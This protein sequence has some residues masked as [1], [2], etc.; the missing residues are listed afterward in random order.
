M[1][2]RFTTEAARR[3][4][5][6]LAEALAV[7]YVEM[8]SRGGDA[9]SAAV[10]DRLRKLVQELYLLSGDDLVRFDEVR[11]ECRVMNDHDVAD[12]IPAAGWYMAL[13]DP[14]FAEGRDP[15]TDEELIEMP[16][17]FA[18]RYFG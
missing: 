5:I 7:W 8:M 18:S 16:M 9:T 11:V 6:F 12:R 10:H 3:A 15:A 17:R 13:P 14:E 2:K 4:W 1:A